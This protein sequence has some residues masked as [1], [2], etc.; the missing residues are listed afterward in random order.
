MCA[1]GNA[2]VPPTTTPWRLVL[3]GYLFT[4]AC[5]TVYV[6]YALSKEIWKRKPSRIVLFVLKLCNG[7]E[8]DWNWRE[9]YY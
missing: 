3:F 7:I 8:I 5:N 9:R 2:A 1:Y 4:M 6:G